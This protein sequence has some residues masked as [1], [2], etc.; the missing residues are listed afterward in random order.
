M[1]SIIKNSFIKVLLL[2][3]N[4]IISFIICSCDQNKSYE[5]RNK[6]NN[7]S[8]KNIFGVK[9]NRD[10]IQ[11]PVVI[12]AKP[13]EIFTIRAPKASKLESDCGNLNGYSYMPNLT[14]ADG[15]ALDVISNGD[16]VSLCD[17][18][19]NLWFG[20][21]NG[22]VSR[23]DG[24]SFKNFTTEHGLANNLVWSIAED[25]GGNI[26]F[27]TNDGISC[28]NGSSFISY[29]QADG[30]INNAVRSITEDK[31]GNLWFCTEGG[32]SRFDGKNF[33]NFS[34]KD[35]PLLDEDQ[36]LFF[37]NFGRY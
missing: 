27:G 34:I 33:I 20:T 15:L 2:I 13:G 26:W 12:K 19:G 11:P 5:G 21:G 3:N 10:S 23:Y 28:Y 32:I 4:F 37:I 36:E 25:K 29:T 7:G 35:G 18:N 30:L 14:T 24:S 1:N 9:M 31:F 17:R 6:P 22:G 16:K 8:L